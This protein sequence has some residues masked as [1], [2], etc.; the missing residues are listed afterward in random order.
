MMILLQNKGVKFESVFV[1][2]GG[3]YPET[4]EYVDMLIK[5]G[6][7]ITVIKGEQ[8]GRNKEG[9]MLNLT[10]YCKEY[11]IMPSRQ[12]RWCTDK[13]K[14]KPMYAYF[15]RPCTVFIGFH[16]GEYQRARPSRDDEITNEFPL[17]E[18]NIDQAGCVKIIM[19]AGLLV[20]MKSGCFYCPFQRIGQFGSLRDK[21][22]ELYCI[23]KGI[24][25]NFNERRKE[26]GKTEYYLKGDM[27]LDKL[28]K[29]DQKELFDGFRL[30][31]Q[32]G[33]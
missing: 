29:E 15:K 4:Y 26:Q 32:C 12:Q 13:F 21:R 7:P 19:E 25:D 6:Y 10:E 28:V 18:N 5:K 3:D 33:Q 17:I 27:P 24:E 31:C 23:T 8:K 14:I 22:P 11:R 20:P 2:H 9:V 16:A 30:P 1:D